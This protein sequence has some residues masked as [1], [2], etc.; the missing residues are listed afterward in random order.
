MDTDRFAAKAGTYDS[1]DER[2]ANV[3]RIAKAIIG[4]SVLH[5]AM[6]IMDFGSGTGLLTERIAPFVRRVTAIDVS[7][8]MNE[9]LERKRSSI[10]CE[11]EI[12]PVDLL[13]TTVDVRLDG[14]VSSMALHHVQDVESLL[15]RMHGLLVD[16]GFL[17]LADLDAEDGH[18]HDDMDGVYHAGF[19]RAHIARL[20]ERAGFREV[21]VVDATVI[22][23]P[24]GEYPV[25]LLKARR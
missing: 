25:F 20:A 15:R 14:I 1:G 6:Q 5:R 11:L 21:E 18:F 24:S 10:E 7:P 23:R 22:T 9:Q 12:L 16:G 19:D 13:A 2:V 17:A 3:H 4:H 8:A